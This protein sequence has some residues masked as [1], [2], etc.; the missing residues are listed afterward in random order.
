MSHVYE[1]ESVDRFESDGFH[2][3]ESISDHFAFFFCRL[4]DSVDI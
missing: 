4:L 2:A 1:I 3:S